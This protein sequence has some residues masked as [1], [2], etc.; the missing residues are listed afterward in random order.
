MW[1]IPSGLTSRGSF[2]GT[3][4]SV[5]AST[6]RRTVGPGSSATPLPYSAAVR[7][8]SIGVTLVVVSL[9]LALALIVSVVAEMIAGSQG[10]GYYIMTM[11]YAMRSSDMYAAIFLL[12]ALGY[13]LNLVLL[14]VEQRVLHWWRRGE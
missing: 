8:A 13:A 1:T 12:A 3:E 2:S 10:I 14:G 11:Q 6:S 5:P 4:I 9:F 7:T